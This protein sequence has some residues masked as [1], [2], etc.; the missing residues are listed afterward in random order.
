MAVLPI[1]RALLPKSADVLVGKTTHTLM[2]AAEHA[3]EAIHVVRLL[4]E[5]YHEI[6]EASAPPDPVRLERFPSITAHLSLSPQ[7]ARRGRSSAKPSSSILDRL[8]TGEAVSRSLAH[9]SGA[10]ALRAARVSPARVDGAAALAADGASCSGQEAT[11]PRGALGEAFNEPLGA[12]QAARLISLARAS[13]F[14]LQTRLS[15]ALFVVG[16]TLVLTVNL[17]NLAVWLASAYEDGRIKPDLSFALGY[18]HHEA[19]LLV[20]VIL[21]FSIGWPLTLLSLKPGA[22]AALRMPIRIASI[23]PLTLSSA[24]AILAVAVLTNPTGTP[25]LAN[26]P[27]ALPIEVASLFAQSA[28]YG[29]HAIAMLLLTRA[30][31]DGADELYG[32]DAIRRLWVIINNLP[33]TAATL[34]LAAVVA[35][36]HVGFYDE[37]PR[38]LVVFAFAAPVGVICTSRLLTIVRVRRALVMLLSRMCG[39]RPGFDAMLAPLSG[40]GAPVSISRELALEPRELCA[41]A[42]SEMQAVTLDE[43][44]L[45]ELV[46][47]FRVGTEAAAQG[48]DAMDALSTVVRSSCSSS[49]PTRSRNSALWPSIKDGRVPTTA[50]LHARASRPQLRA[51]RPAGE[52]ASGWRGLWLLARRARAN[53]PVQPWQ[54]RAALAGDAGC[55][56]SDNDDNNVFTGGRA[57]AG[58][59]I[60][61]QSFGLSTVAVSSQTSRSTACLV[62]PSATGLSPAGASLAMPSGPPVAD[63]YVLY[64]WADGLATAKARAL[65]RWAEQFEARHGRAPTVWVDALCANESLLPIERLARTSATMACCRQ[66]LVLWGPRFVESEMAVALLVAW[67]ALGGSA[68]NSTVLVI[69][70]TRAD[71]AAVPESV[72]AFACTRLRRMRPAERGRDQ[73]AV[74]GAQISEA[75]DYATAGRVNELVRARLPELHAGAIELSA[76]NAA[77]ARASPQRRGSSMRSSDLG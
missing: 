20:T 12:D 3:L 21:A 56:L 72:D 77:R 14:A 73:L 62:P 40:V 71:L 29:A 49:A 24:T 26:N 28:T 16:T 36:Y 38:S 10:T 48:R 63:A 27:L 9:S 2:V 47:A 41:L 60:A 59:A 13:R 23:A 51:S 66:L 55:S 11:M 43:A 75:L 70:E 25:Q 64:D 45:A 6:A 68:A 17:L 8:A 39:T 46:V 69:G 1:T 18:I 54:P 33:L 15:R 52:P 57:S 31:H 42:A 35:R 22:P 19:L 74:V 58:D 30:S 7:L 32:D 53:A 65:S 5:V 34:W 67:H 76:R 37:Q 44:T 61:R 4:R 50:L